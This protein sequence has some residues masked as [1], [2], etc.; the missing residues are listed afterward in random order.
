MIQ[1]SDSN[2]NSVNILFTEARVCIAFFIISFCIFF[3]FF[4]FSVWSKHNVKS[5][6]FNYITVADIFI[7]FM[8]RFINIKSVNQLMSIQVFMAF[9]N[10]FNILFIYCEE[11]NIVM[12]VIE[13]IRLHDTFG[14]SLACRLF[15]KSNCFRNY[16]EFLWIKIQL[17]KVIF[18][19][20]VENCVH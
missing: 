9:A 10:L 2:H 20:G 4:W 1:F 7:N 16:F 12:S 3:F 18:M 5:E 17:R 15:K 8:I 11:K 14:S 6:F 19:K 13:E